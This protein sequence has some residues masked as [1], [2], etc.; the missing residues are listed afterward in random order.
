MRVPCL[1]LLYTVYRFEEF[2]C[3]VSADTVVTIFLFEQL[4]QGKIE[5]A[6]WQETIT[7]FLSCQKSPTWAA[8]VNSRGKVIV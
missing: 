7:S 2:G 4:L 5:F 6:E 3:P 8:V 1:D